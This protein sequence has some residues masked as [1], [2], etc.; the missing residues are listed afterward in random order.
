MELLGHVSGSEPHPLLVCQYCGFVRDDE[1]W[2]R[3]R[4]AAWIAMKAYRNRSAVR[5]RD[6]PFVHTYCPNC[7]PRIQ[8]NKLGLRDLATTAAAHK[9]IRTPWRAWIDRGWI[10]FIKGMVERKKRG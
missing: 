4:P 7:L 10:T 8:A 5:L 3:D 6:V 9:S 2:Q 1:P